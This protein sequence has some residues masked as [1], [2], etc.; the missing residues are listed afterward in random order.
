[1]N[2]GFTG[3]RR[4]M[5]PEQYSVVEELVGV[6]DGHDTAHSGD[7]V[8][9]DVQFHEIASAAGFWTVGH[10][11]ARVRWRAFG[12]YDELWTPKGYLARDRD[13]VNSSDGMIATPGE[14]TQRRQGSGTWYTVRYAWATYTSLT[15][16]YPDGSTQIT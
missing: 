11:P 3:T 14:M 4:G 8:G 2:L 9:S 10:P 1:M 7:C 16:I 6:W 12:K 13:I 5:T 15:I